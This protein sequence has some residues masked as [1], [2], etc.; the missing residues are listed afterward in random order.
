MTVIWASANRDGAVFEDADQFRPDRDQ[1]Q[2][3]LYGAGIHICP[4]A[5][6]ARMQLRVVLDELLSGI[7]NFVLPLGTE[8][9]RAV[10]PAGGYASFNLQIN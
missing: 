4:G 5:A 6:L 9:I 7:G 8:A 3:L 1:S 10:Y 2:N